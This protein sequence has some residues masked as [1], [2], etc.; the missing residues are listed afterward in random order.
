[1]LSIDLAA[2][3]IVTFSGDGALDYDV[4]VK[5]WGI[6]ATPSLGKRLPAFGLRP[7]L[8]TDGQQKYLMLVDH[9][10][11]DAFIDDMKTAKLEIVG[12]LPESLESGT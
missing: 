4:G 7:V 10:R 2:D 1:V 11:M 5:S 3:E 6:Y 12:W 8:I 9:T